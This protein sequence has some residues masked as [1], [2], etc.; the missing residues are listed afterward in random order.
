MIN[1]I[2]WVL[3]WFGLIYLPRLLLLGVRW[4]DEHRFLQINPDK[5]WLISGYKLILILWIPLS[6]IVTVRYNQDAS[7]TSFFLYVGFIP[8]IGLGILKGIIEIIFGTSRFWGFKVSEKFTIKIPFIMTP[9]GN[10]KMYKFYF[11]MNTKRVKPVG[12]AR[13]LLN[14]GVLFVLIFF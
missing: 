9:W 14:L 13:L 1:F 5:E 11:I 6:T 4:I 8:L 2:G 12:V 10:L 3:V 7:A